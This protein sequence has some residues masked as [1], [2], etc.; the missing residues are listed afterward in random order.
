MKNKIVQNNLISCLIAVVLTAIICIVTYSHF[1][2]GNLTLQAENQAYILRE[3]CEAET[4]DTSALKALEGSFKSRVTL[5]GAD[6]SVLFD[7]THDE[8]VLE[9][10]LEREEI[11]QA[12]ENNK[13]S[14]QRFSYTDGVT[15]YYYALKLSD[16]KIIRVGV[17]SNQAFSEAILPNLPVIVM[18]IIAI[19]AMVF[20]VAEKTTKRIVST[21]EHF[22][23]DIEGGTS[24]DELSPFIEKIRTQNETIKKQIGKTA[25][26]KDKLASIFSNME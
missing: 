6:G 26:E 5:I 7:S 17:R 14:S 22:N 8:T 15:N 25:A 12:V 18:A 21:I 16:G 2:S 4:D 1:I 13:G 11:I 24:Y 10:H 23:F 20:V 3:I 19:L 9:N